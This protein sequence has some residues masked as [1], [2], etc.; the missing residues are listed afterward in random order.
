MAYEMLSL[1]EESIESD[2][3]G[4]IIDVETI[5]YFEWDKYTDRDTRHYRQSPVIFG[6]MG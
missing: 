2:F 6:F 4:T 5:G 1:Y 3:N